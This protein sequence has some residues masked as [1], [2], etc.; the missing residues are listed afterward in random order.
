[1]NDGPTEAGPIP[2]TDLNAWQFDLPLEA[3]AQARV[4]HR[5]AGQRWT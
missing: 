5:A 2:K 4:I 3:D 1:M